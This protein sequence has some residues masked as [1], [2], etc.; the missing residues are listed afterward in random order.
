MST[1]CSSSVPTITGSAVSFPP[2]RESFALNFSVPAMLARPYPISTGGSLFE[3]HERSAAERRAEPV[4]VSGTQIKGGAAFVEAPV[5]L[6]VKA[7]DAVGG[8]HER[9]RV[10]IQP[11]EARDDVLVAS[12]E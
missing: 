5:F 9:R 11:D 2:G 10:C 8:L 1:A 4:S 12:A 7:R 3:R 6:A